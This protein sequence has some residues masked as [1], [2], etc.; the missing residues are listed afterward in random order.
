[1]DKNEQQKINEL[2]KIISLG[3]KLNKDVRPDKKKLEILI[4]RQNNSTQKEN[5]TNN[6]EK[7]LLKKEINEKDDNLNIDTINY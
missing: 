2:K 7:P 1:M 3:E 4:D 6:I 5:Q